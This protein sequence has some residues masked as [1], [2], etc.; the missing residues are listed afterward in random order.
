MED[1]KPAQPRL[2]SVI[3]PVH[4]MERFLP[5]TLDSILASDYPALEVVVVNDG[6]SDGSLAVAKGYAA[7]DRRVKIITQRN[8]GVCR[9]RNTAIHCAAGH[10]ILPVDADN[11]IE[12]TF[13]SRA[14]A[15][16]E[17]RPGIK[18]VAPRA[19]FFGSR[20][21]EWRL[22][23]FSLRLLARKNIM[24]TCALF[25]REEWERTGGYCEEIVAREDWEFWIAV[26]KDGGDV[27][28]L[29]SIELHYRVQRRSKRVNDRR[30]KHHVVDVL[31]RR[32]P[33]FFEREL[34]GPLRYRRTWSG[35]INRL[36]RLFHPRR[37]FI[38][39]AYAPL[40]YYAKSLPR[41]FAMGA[42]ICI[43]EGRNE[44]RVMRH[45]AEQ[46]VVKSFR[47]PNFVNRVAY[48]L[49]RASKAERSYLNALRLREAGIGTP[50]PV[51]YYTE[52]AGLLFSR[53]YYVCRKSACPYT[54][55]RLIG[56]RYPNQEAP[57][58]AIARTVARMHD[59][60]FLHKDLS[61]GNILFG[62]EADGIRVEII[63]LNRIRFHEPLT[64]EDGCR[65]LAERLPATDRMQA[66]LAD[67]Y[68]RARGFDAAQCLALIR[69]FN[70]EKH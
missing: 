47:V 26:L 50:E 27:V 34:H 58:R 9:A 30:F 15:A 10:Y 61:R 7:R 13:V 52:R 45:G 65:N 68:A 42:G 28:R 66:I 55:A 23:P 51:A 11:R 8:S 17:S 39:P 12:P 70:I 6:S 48:G 24:D 38:N 43:H 5:E 64:M 31:N 60:G 57:L 40:R 1:Q 2:V 16:I 69:R 32:H 25:R 49:L 41:L 67:E 4:N 56:G 37:V 46:Y 18:V 19:D 63:D 36:H 29:P 14:V 35:L 20:T 3:V 22:P 62:A 53:S 54:Y 59:N 21:G 44:L 33:D